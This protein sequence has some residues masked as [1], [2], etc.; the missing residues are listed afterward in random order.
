MWLWPINSLLS[1]RCTAQSP[2]QKSKSERGVGGCSLMLSRLQ[3]RP[4]SAQDFCDIQ[5]DYIKVEN[6]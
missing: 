1:R 2:T 4:A 6:A 5:I 3:H